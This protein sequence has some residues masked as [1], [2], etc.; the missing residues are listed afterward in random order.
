MRGYSYSL[1]QETGFPRSYAK[2]SDSRQS[3]LSP[4]PE[5][6]HHQ[7]LSSASVSSS[8]STAFSSSSSPD[9]RNSRRSPWKDPTY[10]EWHLDQTVS[11]GGCVLRDA[12]KKKRFFWRRTP[13]SSS[14]QVSVLLRDV[15]QFCESVV[16]RQFAR[17]SQSNT[18]KLQPQ[19]EEGTGQLEGLDNSPFCSF[20][21]PSPSG[22]LRESTH[23]APLHYP[24]GSET[25][26]MI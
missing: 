21:N 9:D 6:R 1:I 22:S 10:R 14:S 16:R 23:R 19:L 25:T 17:A 8:A 24:A 18:Q 11:R 12:P 4:G 26:S 5:C 7:L 15:L 13:S 20:P 2:T 3:A